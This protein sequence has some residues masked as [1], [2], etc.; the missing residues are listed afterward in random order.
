MITIEVSV[1]GLKGG[2]CKPRNCLVLSHKLLSEPRK[3]GNYDP[4]GKVWDR[5]KK[6]GNR[7]GW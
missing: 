1:L 6:G 7:K 2:E 3:W 5:V 4:D